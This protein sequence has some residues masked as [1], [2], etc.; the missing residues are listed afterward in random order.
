VLVNKLDDLVHLLGGLFYLVD[1]L[2]D[3]LYFIPGGGLVAPSELVPG[4]PEL[5]Q[6]ILKRLH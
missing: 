4:A 3:L 2:D 6:N 1:V 5:A